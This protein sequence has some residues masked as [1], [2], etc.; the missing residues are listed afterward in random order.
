MKT[1][2]ICLLFATVLCL[3]LAQDDGQSPQ[4]VIFVG[5]PSKAGKAG[6]GKYYTYFERTP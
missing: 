6:S 5:D 3:A 1:T 2:I 4:P